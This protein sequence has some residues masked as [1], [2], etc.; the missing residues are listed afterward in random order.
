MITKTGALLANHVEALAAIS[1][2]SRLNINSAAIKKNFTPVSTN[3][4]E[5][6]TFTFTLA[7]LARQQSWITEVDVPPLYCPAGGNR[8][9]PAASCINWVRCDEQEQQCGVG[10]EESLEG[11]DVHATTSRGH[12]SE[13]YGWRSPWPLT[14]SAPRE[15]SQAFSTLH[16]TLIWGVSAAIETLPTT[17]TW[18][19]TFFPAFVEGGKQQQQ[20]CFST[21]QN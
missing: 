2:L 18:P 3:L 20:C 11:T 16:E 19:M 6:A 9:E 4:N 15:R 13:S 8:G 10:G 5:A 21:F 1:K 17:M 7:L 14:S 12:R